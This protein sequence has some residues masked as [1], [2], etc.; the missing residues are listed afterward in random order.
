MYLIRQTGD[1]TAS[2][3]LAL[4]ARVSHASSGRVLRVLTNEQYL[5][6]YTSRA[7]DGTLIGKS[8]QPYA[9]HA[10]ICL[11]CQGYPDGPNNPEMGDIILRPG[12]IFNRTTLYSFSTF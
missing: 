9:R 4:A 10:G 2:Q 1:E 11:E 3:Q 8:G 5:Q 6:L 12:Q 7:F